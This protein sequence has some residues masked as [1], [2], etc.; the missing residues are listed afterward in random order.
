LKSD[1]LSL[2][3]FSLE[4]AFQELENKSEILG[5]SIEYLEQYKTSLDK[6]LSLFR[7]NL[8]SLRSGY[9]VKDEQKLITEQHKE[10][11]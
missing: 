1:G 4:R 7:L 11:V 6:H 8:N 3:W 10:E 9:E 2:M 5:Q